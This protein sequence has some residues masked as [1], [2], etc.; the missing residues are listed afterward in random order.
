MT[1]S[2]PFGH[3]GVVI[4]YNANPAIGTVGVYPLVSTPDDPPWSDDDQHALAQ[5]PDVGT[6]QEQADA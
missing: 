1:C 6:P 5:H 4:I 3:D 2:K